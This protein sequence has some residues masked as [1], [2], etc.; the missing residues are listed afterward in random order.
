MEPE[1]AAYYERKPVNALYNWGLPPAEPL[2]EQ[3]KNR[4]G[5]L[6]G[7]PV[8]ERFIPDDFQASNWNPYR[9][10]L[11]KQN[12]DKWL[13]HVKTATQIVH[14]VDLSKRPEEDSWMQP[15]VPYLYDSDNDV[16]HWGGYYDTHGDMR[17]HIDP[18]YRGNPANL[19]PMYFLEGRVD[20]PMNPTRHSVW[21][22]NY[23]GEGQ[24][25]AMG[26]AE[27]AVGAPIDLAE[28]PDDILFHAP[29]RRQATE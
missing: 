25:E 2:R 5:E 26:K 1:N 22:H 7:S 27:K 24:A 21:E 4:I 11:D 10:D 29:W 13:A 16:L 23:P 18:W 9:G 14:H 19:M 6:V 28:D 3:I 12:D 17:Y 20:D 8:D 15:A